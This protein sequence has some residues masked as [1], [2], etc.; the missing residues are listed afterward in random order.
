MQQNPGAEVDISRLLRFERDHG[1]AAWP[2]GDF[3][4]EDFC[5]N[6]DLTK[7]DFPFLSEDIETLNRWETRTEEQVGMWKA[8]A[9]AVTRWFPEL[10]AYCPGQPP[11]QIAAA[12]SKVGR[13]HDFV[14][15]VYESFRPREFPA[16]HLL[17]GRWA[18]FRHTQL[19]LLAALQFVRKYGP[20]NTNVV[21]TELH[22]DVLD[23]DYLILATLVAAFASYD[24][25]P[26]E[27]FLIAC[28]SGKLIPDRL[29]GTAEAD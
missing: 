4:K 22:N 28:P 24:R 9:C 5:F 3:L 11:I 6:P 29:D 19:H 10:E 12:M 14:R 21:A 8:Q 17:D 26:R 15:G 16:G 25:E 1:R 2:M 27:L 13:D 18:L 7:P 23:L 20:T